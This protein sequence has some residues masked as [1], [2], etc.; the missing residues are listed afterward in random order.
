MS[1]HTMNTSSHHGVA[2]SLRIILYS[3]VINYLITQVKEMSKTEY[4]T[5]QWIVS[6]EILKKQ[7]F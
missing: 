1:N 3:L 2:W 7:L 4:H 6:S 5:A